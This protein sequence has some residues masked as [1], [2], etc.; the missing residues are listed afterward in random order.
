MLL[1][2]QTLFTVFGSLQILGGMVLILLYFLKRC[3]KDWVQLEY[4][5]AKD[6][7]DLSLT[8]DIRINHH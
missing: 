3:V 6:M 7:E 2:T 5:N 8:P 1:E 4:A